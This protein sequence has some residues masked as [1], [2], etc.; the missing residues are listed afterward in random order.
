MKIVMPWPST[1]LSPNARVHPMTKAGFV[2]RAR[3]YAHYATIEQLGEMCKQDAA[4]L[5]RPLS[6][7]LTFMAPDK[8]RRDRDNLLASMKSAIDGVCQALGI[9][10]AEFHQV[11]VGTGQVVAGGRVE[12]E[13]RGAQ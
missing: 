4:R 2:R 10:D 9:D 5:Q 13:I 6:L 7:T 8:R 3:A 11:T 1:E 12:L